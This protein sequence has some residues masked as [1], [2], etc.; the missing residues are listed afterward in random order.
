MNWRFVQ[1]GIDKIKSTIKN[2]FG[3]NQE[4]TDDGDSLYMPD[5]SHFRRTV[6][7]RCAAPM[8]VQEELHDA[9]RVVDALRT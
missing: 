7:P 1:N 2:A 6:L 5:G 8:T 4:L 3:S 9:M